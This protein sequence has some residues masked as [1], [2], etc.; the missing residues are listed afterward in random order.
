MEKQDGRISGMVK[1]VGVAVGATLASGLALAQDGPDISGA[2]DAFASA[3]TAIAA[4]GAA[5][6]VAASAGIVFRW[7]T[8]FLVK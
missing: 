2:T 6:V 3:G 4:V 1:K 8:A 5:M 7:V